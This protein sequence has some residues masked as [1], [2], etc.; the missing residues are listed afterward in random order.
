MCVKFPEQKRYV[1]LEWPLT[2]NITTLRS[3]FTLDLSCVV[4]RRVQGFGSGRP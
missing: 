2:E 3:T 4:A 1:T